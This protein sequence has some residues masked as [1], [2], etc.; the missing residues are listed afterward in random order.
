MDSIYSTYMEMF[1][2]PKKNKTNISKTNSDII[3]EQILL[4]LN[5]IARFLKN[6]EKDALSSFIQILRLQNYDISLYVSIPCIDEVTYCLQFQNYNI[7]FY[8]IPKI[9]SDILIK[10]SIPNCS[11]YFGPNSNPNKQQILNIYFTKP[12][13]NKKL[14]KELY[15]QK[16][17]QQKLNNQPIK[18]REQSI[19]DIWLQYIGYFRSK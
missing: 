16:E 6:P 15:T 4:H 17:K 8:A 2:S 5:D 14:L 10:K 9:M 18:Y 1:D 3:R 11:F 19:Q 13:F 7:T 12:K